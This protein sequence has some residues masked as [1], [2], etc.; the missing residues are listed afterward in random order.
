MIGAERSKYLMWFVTHTSFSSIYFT[1]LSSLAKNIIYLSIL[2]LM[3]SINRN[4]LYGSTYEKIL[5]KMLN[6]SN[7]YFN[8]KCL[9][10]LY[11]FFLLMLRML[12]SKTL[13]KVCL[14]W[15]SLSN[16]EVILT[17]NS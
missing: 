10:I 13:F 7:H 14:T 17:V 4:I 1:I 12:Q 15:P 16:L 5:D 8:H 6:L 9:L 3:K 11:M 2:L